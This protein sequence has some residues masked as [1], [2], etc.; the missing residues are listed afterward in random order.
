M[1][2]AVIMVGEAGGQTESAAWVQDARRAAARD[3]LEQLSRQPL[4]EQIVVV[5]P[6]PLSPTNRAPVQHLAS[7]SGP[8]HVGSYLARIAEDLQENRLLYFGGGSAPLLGDDELGTILA[9]LQSTERGVVTNN[10]YASDWAGVVP[11]GVLSDWR[12]R[13]PKDNMIAWVLSTEANLPVHAQPASAASRLDIDTPTDLLALRL[14]PGTRP[15]LSRFLAALPL[16]TSRLEAA[17]DVLAKPASQVFIAGRIGPEAWLALN[18]V[19]RCWLRVLSEERGMSSSGRRDRGEAYSFLAEHIDAVGL[20]HFFDRLSV[21]ADAAF[22]DSRVLLAH[23]RLWPAEAERYASDLGLTAH[24][25]NGWLKEFTVA[26]LRAPI[27]VVL[28]GHGLMAGD[29]LAFCELL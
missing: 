15:F 7:S 21:Q 14:H 28:G 5:S 4:V 12:E 18:R 16:D 25:S 26:A 29:M 6:K 22:I 13:L 1:V 17:L 2:T 8:V 27:P 10:Q 3:L 24:I 11:A 19:T 9:R 23:H 20:T